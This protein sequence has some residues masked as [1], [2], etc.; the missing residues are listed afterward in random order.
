MKQIWV[1]SSAAALILVLTVLGASMKAATLRSDESGPG[2]GNSTHWV[3]GASMKAATLRWDE[4]GPG[5]W[6]STHWVGGTAS[7]PDET[8]NAV[9]P[10]DV[11]TVGTGGGSA[12]SLTVNNRGGIVISAGQT[13]SVAEEVGF[14]AGTTLALGADATL[15]AG[16]GFINSLTT[17]GDATINASFG[18]LTVTRFSDGGFSGSKLTKQ[19]PGTLLL[20]NTLLDSLNLHVAAGR[21]TIAGG[22]TGTPIV[23]DEAT[24]HDNTFSNFTI[25]PDLSNSDYADTHSNNGVVV[26]SSEAHWLSGWPGVVVDGHGQQS[27]DSPGESLFADWPIWIMLDLQDTVG[28]T[29]VNTY[30]RH[31]WQNSGDGGRTPQVYSLYGS[32]AATAPNPG[33]LN[34]WN[35]IA[36]VDTV[37]GSTG[38]IH[39]GNCGVSIQEQQGGVFGQF[40]YLLLNDLHSRPGHGGTFYGEVDVVTGT[41]GPAS[42]TLGELTMGAGTE[43][44]LETAET[45][46][47][48]EFIDAGHEASIHGDVR[49]TGGLSPNDGTG[50]LNVAGY[51]LMED[52]VQ[53]VCE[54]DQQSNDLVVATGD[55]YLGGTLTLRPLGK[56]E[57]VG[58]ATRTILRTT[59]EGSVYQEFAHVPS[60]G[61]HLG[62][63]VFLGDQAITRTISTIGIHLFQA[64]DGDANG[65]RVIDQDDVDAITTADIF[66]TGIPGDW[67]KGDFTGDAIVNGDDVQALLA[68]NLFDRGM[69]DDVVSGGGE[70]MLELTVTPGGLLIDTHGETINGYVLTSIAAVFTGDPA[71]N[72]GLF[73]EDQDDRISGNHF[74]ALGGT[75]LLGDVVGEEFALAG[76]LD[77]LT[78]TYTIEGE[79]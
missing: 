35:H 39:P 23:F 63:G 24:P 16:G 70:G 79:P 56:L 74:F 46:A 65:D 49:L 14:D 29:Q 18:N 27:N 3:L 37:Q 72:L 47:T 11:V 48:L 55:L 76:L 21:V 9:V 1:A 45:Q 2:N 10:T 20:K 7:V 60:T 30:S 58:D 22:G 71:D 62:Y 66:A 75:H 5:N 4:S 13:L 44:R 78:F 53:Y 31:E 33:D 28:V 17:A 59:G 52:G 54:L 32:D 69:Y 36:D 41:V 61:E 43:L 6:N 19:G 50:T 34:A 8:I 25:V 40:R 38:T 12:L 51:L 26:T 42:V 77:D 73:Q 67:T 68:T 64:A 57:T 15:S